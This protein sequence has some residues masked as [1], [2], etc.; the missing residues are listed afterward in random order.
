[1]FRF[2]CGQTAGESECAGKANQ[3]SASTH[4][5]MLE[6]LL[7]TITNVN[8]DN[9]AIEHQIEAVYIDK[10][11]EAVSKWKQLLKLRILNI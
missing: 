10:R 7:I 11:K 4:R 5:T 9:Y 3:P 1:M 2:Q 6:G 8:F